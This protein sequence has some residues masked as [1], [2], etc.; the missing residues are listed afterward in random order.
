MPR[1]T[2]A[3]RAMNTINIAP[4]LIASCHPMVVPLAAASRTFASSIGTSILSFPRVSGS[5]FSGTITLAMTKA[6]GAESTEP[7]M[8]CAAILG[9]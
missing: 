8:R 6:A 9:K 7:E 3:S 1:L 5:S 2:I 4:T